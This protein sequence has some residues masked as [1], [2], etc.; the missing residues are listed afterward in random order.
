D[1]RD[2]LQSVVSSEAELTEPVVLNVASELLNAELE[3]KNYIASRSGVAD[4]NQDDEDQIVPT[5]EYRQV[6]A[7]V[8]TEGLNNFSEAKEAILSFLSGIGD[9]TQLEIILKRLEEVRGV[10]M[11]MP[12]DRVEAQIVK[13]QNYIRAALLNNDHKADDEEQDT[14]ADVVTSIEYFFEALSEG[15]PGIEQGLSAGDEAAEKLEKIALSYGDSVI[16]SSQEAEVEDVAAPDTGEVEKQEQKEQKEKKAPIIS[17]PVAVGLSVVDEY[18][19]LADDADE[20]IV[21]IFIE[22]AI[23][24]LGELHSN[25]PIWKANNDDEEALAIIRRSFHTLKGSGR[26][27]GADLIGEFAWKFENMLNR[28]IDKKIVVSDSLYQAL[29][30]ALAVLPQ[31]IEQLKGNREPIANMAQLMSNADALADGRDVVIATGEVTEVDVI[32]HEVEAEQDSVEAEEIAIELPVDNDDDLAVDMSFDND[33]LAIDMS[34][35]NDDEIVISEDISADVAIG[36]SSDLDILELDPVNNVEQEEIEIS[37][38]DEITDIEMD[39]FA[40]DEVIAIADVL[41]IS[42]TTE[43]LTEEIISLDVADIVEDVPEAY[44][45]IIDEDGVADSASSSALNIDPML[46]KIYH[47]ESVGHINNVQTQLDEHE[48]SG[49]ALQA[50]KNLIRAFHTLYG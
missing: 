41:D 22:E 26:L 46:L 3:L 38:V 9:K 14:V 49:Q 23:E 10:S 12:M 7:A 27:L 37:V 45:V 8:V 33:D 24:V 2:V 1:Q 13:L 15:R 47:D 30:E 42:D 44:E 29:D 48:S 16:E 17:N 28:I 32:Q 34:L 40:D 39:D 50:D 11:M 20:E 36:D 5:A 31:L 18:A 21:E 43:D 6:V 19:I 4:I 35:D 25:L